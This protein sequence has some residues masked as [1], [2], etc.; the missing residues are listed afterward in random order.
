MTK[1]LNRVLEH[2]VSVGALIEIAVWLAIP[3]LSI[4]F[5]WA[6]RHTEQVHQIQTRLEQVL[7]SGADVGAY[8]LTGHCG[9]LP[10]RSPMGAQP[11]DSQTK[12]EPP[13]TL[14]VAPVTYPLRLDAR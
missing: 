3:Y 4:G 12:S 14:M 1:P 9:R 5:V 13:S 6:P 2:R 11:N 8:G 10:S 7:P